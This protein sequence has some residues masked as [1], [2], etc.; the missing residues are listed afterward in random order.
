MNY[1]DDPNGDLYETKTLNGR[2]YLVFLTSYVRISLAVEDSLLFDEAPLTIRVMPD[3]INAHSGVDNLM[4][5]IIISVII[6]AAFVY[7]I[8]YTLPENI[9][10]KMVY[11][12]QA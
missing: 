6:L 12:K 3:E 7:G 2:K 5:S 1:Q 10:D 4:A 8:L 11:F 9:R